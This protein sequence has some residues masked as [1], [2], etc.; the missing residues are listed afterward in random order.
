MFRF[1]ISILG[2][3]A[4]LACGSAFAQGSTTAYVT[5]NTGQTGGHVYSVNTLT[6]V[7]TQI[8]SLGGTPEGVVYG[9]D[10]R[11][12]VCDP[13]NGA[14]RRMDPNGTNIHTV[15][16]AIG[17]SP[18]QQPQCGRFS[19]AGDFYVTSKAAGSGVWKFTAAG[20]A[21]SLPATPANVLGSSQLG[22]NFAGGD[23]TQANNGDFLIVDRAN[24][25]VFLSTAPNY[26]TATALITGLGANAATGIA[27]SSTGDI[28][29]ADAGASNSVLHYNSSG[30]SMTTCVS[31]TSTTKPYFMK[32]SA[33]DTLY[34]A[35]SEDDTNEG[36]D[37]DNDPFI[38]GKIWSV[39]IST[40]TKAQI[41]SMPTQGDGENR[42]AFG[43]ALPPTS[44]APE[45][46]TISTAT[47]RNFN[48][49][50]S[51]FL[52]SGTSPSTCTATVQATQTLLS[53][54]QAAFALPAGSSL[55]PYLGEA[56]FGTRYSVTSTNCTTA[57][58]LIGAF[59]PDLKNPRIVF[60]HPDISNV[61]RS[62]SILTA[63]AVYPL[64]GPIPGDGSV[65]GKVPSFSDFYLIDEGLSNVSGVAGTFCGFNPPLNNTT[66]PTGAP[67]F[68]ISSGTIPVKFQLGLGANC[69]KQIT[70]ATALLSVARVDSGFTPIIPLKFDG[71]G[72]SSAIFGVT[73]KQYHLNLD[74]STYAPGTYSVT[75][76]FLS[77]NAA[78]VTTY[79]KLVP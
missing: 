61:S 53:S 67:V 75:V 74:I 58:A 45:T 11:L 3:A 19:S 35:T 20:L 31:F 43:L 33:D 32:F 21:G 38:N 4:L 15:Y 44:T 24:G 42:A 64:N 54:L 28:F 29:V 13:T 71:L 70:N 66:S 79:F 8:A 62:C 25:K 2:L 12:Y 68:S 63:T 55:V 49:N 69:N 40:C 57:N 39:N 47:G 37:T 56:G 17:S 41:A 6:S 14:V 5:D 65:G 52:I 10:N 76:T 9:P 27:R 16:Q 46:K 36:P 23:L 51:S 18:L 60:C 7:V 1:R 78:P 77:G 72:D 50:F 22:S 30:G 34:V 73:G 48:F 26:S 59:T